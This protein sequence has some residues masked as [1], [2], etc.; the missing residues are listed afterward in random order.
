MPLFT[1]TKLLTV[2][3][4]DTENASATFYEFLLCFCLMSPF[5][6]LEYLGSCFAF[7]G[8]R[9]SVSKFRDIFANRFR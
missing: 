3:V 7:V 6:I 9:S 1:R 4:A 8:A 2:N 5:P